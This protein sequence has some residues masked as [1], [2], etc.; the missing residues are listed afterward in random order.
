MNN[1]MF[2]L[3]EMRAYWAAESGRNYSDSEKFKRLGQLGGVVA[4]G[5]FFAVVAGEYA[6]GL[7][8]IAIGSA[9]IAYDAWNSQRQMQQCLEATEQAFNCEFALRNPGSEI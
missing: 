1:D 2:R 7:S 6:A 3:Q 8:A 9:G 4:V 5:G